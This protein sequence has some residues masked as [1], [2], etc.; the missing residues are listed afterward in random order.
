MTLKAQTVEPF[1]SAQM[2]FLLRNRVRLSVI[3]FSVILLTDFLEGIRPRA[4][5]SLNDKWGVLGLFIV[6]SGL[7]LRSW[8]AGIISKGTNLATKG[9]YALTRH[10]LYAGTLLM[11][12]GFCVIIP[13]GRNIWAVAVLALAVYLP[14]IRREEAKNLKR[15][16]EEWERYVKGTS[17]FFPRRFPADIGAGWSFKQ[18]LSNREYNAVI[19]G[20]IVMVLLGLWRKLLF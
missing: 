6:L 17:M 5:A 19:V 14:K 11:V 18:W 12:I 9:P 10:P 20:L 7:F 2:D 3:V 1:Y 4:I 16:G 13:D 8:S 15:F